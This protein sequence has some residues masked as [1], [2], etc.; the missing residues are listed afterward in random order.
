[1]KE[2]R[3]EGRKERNHAPFIDVF[4]YFILCQIPFTKIV[5]INNGV[6]DINSKSI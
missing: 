5:L 6:K 2:G 4:S 3:N 1:M